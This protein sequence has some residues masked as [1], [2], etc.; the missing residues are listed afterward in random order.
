MHGAE[1]GQGEDAER[2]LVPG[3][4]AQRGGRL[5]AIEE[6]QRLGRI[7]THFG[8]RRGKPVDQGL[9]GF[10]SD[11]LQLNGGFGRRGRVEQLLPQH[12]QALRPLER[13]F[14]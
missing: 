7:E 10:R 11:R 6:R 3:D 13:R 2:R 14:A 4:L 9:G 1:G 8:I 12:G 5:A